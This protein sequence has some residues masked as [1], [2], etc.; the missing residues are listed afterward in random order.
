M[1]RKPKGQTL[2]PAYEFDSAYI[3]YNNKVYRPG[4][5]LVAP[6]GATLTARAFV[7]NTNNTAGTACYYVKWGGQIRCWK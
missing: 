4:D 1:A 3:W 7:N 6:A 5:T 2:G